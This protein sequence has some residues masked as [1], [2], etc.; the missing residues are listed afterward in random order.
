MSQITRCPACRTSFRVVADQL[1]ISGGWV[2][3]GRCKEVFDASTNLLADVRYAPVRQNKG[4]EAATPSAS[5]APGDRP[6]SAQPP[7]YW[8]RRFRHRIS[9]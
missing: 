3:C 7:R 9:R 6:A 8:C 5:P 1:R 2:R 4:A